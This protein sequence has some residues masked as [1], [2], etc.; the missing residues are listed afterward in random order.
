MRNIYVTEAGVA[1]P[2]LF[3]N[4]GF[5]INISKQMVGDKTD[6]EQYHQNHNQFQTP[7]FQ[8]RV[9][10][11]FFGKNQNNVSVTEQNDNQWYG[12]PCDAPADTVR[13]VFSDQVVGGCVKTRVW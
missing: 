7:L 9:N 12:K 6:R 10:V 5:Q 4:P 8:Q 2:I 3:R 1:N 13:Q 11:G